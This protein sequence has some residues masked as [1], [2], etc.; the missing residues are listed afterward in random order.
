[1][2]LPVER[3]ADKEE[4]TRKLGSKKE[5]HNGRTTR[6]VAMS[7]PYEASDKRRGEAGFIWFERNQHWGG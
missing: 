4:G 5:R 1:V 6:R 7:V 3:P 2:G